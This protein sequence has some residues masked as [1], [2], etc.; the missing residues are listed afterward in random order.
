MPKLA[1]VADSVAPTEAADVVKAA[2]DHTWTSECGDSAASRER[3]L[4][5]VSTGE[6]PCRLLEML[7]RLVRVVKQRNVDPLSLGERNVEVVG[8]IGW[9]SN[10]RKTK[11]RRHYRRSIFSRKARVLDQGLYVA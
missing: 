1:I 11:V 10:H 4:K 3:R 5:I 9:I 7:D 6:Q 2:P 8:V